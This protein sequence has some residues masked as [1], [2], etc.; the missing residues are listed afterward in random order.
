M[1]RLIA[2]L[3]VEGQEKLDGHELKIVVFNS[4]LFCAHHTTRFRIINISSSSF[5]IL[6]FLLTKEESRATEQEDDEQN[7]TGHCTVDGLIRGEW[8][9]LG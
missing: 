3:Y 2:M 8:R 9:R 4:T 1:I 5:L 7:E 6:S